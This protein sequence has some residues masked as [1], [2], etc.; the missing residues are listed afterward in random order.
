MF[1]V[2][3]G[4]MTAVGF[5][6]PLRP[7]AVDDWVEDLYWHRHG[8]RQSQRKWD[9]EMVMRLACHRTRGRLSFTTVAHL[10]TLAG[11]LD[12]LRGYTGQ[13][14][15]AMGDPLRELRDV[16]PDTWQSMLRVVDLPVID[17]RVILWSLTGTTLRDRTN[18][19]VARAL[20]QIPLP[21]PLSEI[22]EL[23]QIYDLYSAA[24]ELLE[25]TLLDLVEELSQTRPI[26]ALQA[27]LRPSLV[28]D[29]TSRLQLHHQTRGH[30]GDP[31]RAIPT[32][33]YT[34]KPTLT[35]SMGTS[36]LS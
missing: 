26:A 1:T 24:V 34:S 12:Q 36:Q 13:I 3:D 30:P 32:Q 29:L 33:A 27:L 11:Q 2:H 15:L 31:R 17:A 7:R 16:C 9:A 35:V 21:N 22:W 8:F 4:R 20:A 10:R 14:E 18:P 19:T 28:G 25:D 23:R 6:A 5:P